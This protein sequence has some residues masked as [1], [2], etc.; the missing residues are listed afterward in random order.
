MLF[1]LG[2][3]ARQGA[4]NS[5][6]QRLC[7][8]IFTK[9]DKPASVE[10]INPVSET[11]HSGTELVTYVSHDVEDGVWQFLG[12]SMSDGGGPVISCFH[13]PIDRDPSLVELADLPLGWHAERSRV[14]EPWTRKKHQRDDASE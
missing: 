12:D 7:A 2:D 5:L 6:Q 4:G 14:G 1:G 3:L 9:S 8:S 13:H 11:V 10:R